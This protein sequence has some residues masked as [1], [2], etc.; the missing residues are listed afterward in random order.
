MCKICEL[1]NA[2]R[3]EPTPFTEDDFNRLSNDVWTGMVT[4]YNLPVSVYLKTSN[5]LIKGVDSGFGK[6]IMDAEFNSPDWLMLADLHENIYIF[7]AAKTYQEVRTMSNLLLQPDLKANFYA[8]K[9]EAEKVFHDYNAAYLEAEYNTAKASSRMAAEWMRIVETEDVLPY[10][11]YQT[12]GDGRVRPT[13]RQ[14][15]NI[16]RKTDDKFWD[17]YYPPNGWNCRCT[18]QQLLEGE[19]TDIL[20]IPNI[21]DDVPPLFKMNSGKDRIIFKDKGKN[22]HPYFDVARGDKPYA[23]RNFDLPIPQPER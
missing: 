5:H 17:E 3:N 4:R 12:V 8:F 23:M 20:A 10:L 1:Y 9:Q 7:S 18:V 22:K 21:D 16:I 15:D 19:Q 13:H 11:Q 6:R 14:L 2:V